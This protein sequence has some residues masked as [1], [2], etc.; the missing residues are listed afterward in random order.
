M[1]YRD[2]FKSAYARPSDPNFGPYSFQERL[3]CE[4]W[5]DLLDVPTGMGKTASVVLAWLWKRGW[6]QDKR[7]ESPETETPRRLVYCL[8]MRVLVE[9]TYRN[10]ETWLRN[11]G[12]GGHAGQGKVSVHLLMGGSDDVEKAT[13]AEHPEEDMI[14]IGTQDM[15]LSRALNRGYG[16]IRFKWPVHFGL[17]NQDCMWVMDEIQLMGPGLWTSAQLDWMR[18]KRFQALTPCRT[19]WMSATIGT[20]FLKTT[21]RKKDGLDQFEPFDPELD[22]PEPIASV[23]DE[24]KRRRSA[25]RPVTLFK[26]EGGKKALPLH[27][28]IAADACKA[29]GEGTLTLVICNTVQMAQDIFRCLADDGPPK[30]LL[31]SRFRGCDRQAAESTLSE[32][33]ARRSKAANGR[34]DG[35]PGLVCVSTQVVEAGIDIS[36]HRLWS[37]LAPWPSM[38]QRLGRLNRDGRDND[39]KAYVWERPNP[40]KWKHD[41]ENWIG[42]YREKELKDA[43]VLLDALA[44]PSAREPF[45]Q[46]V[47]ELKEIKDKSGKIIERALEPQFEP[48][49]RALDVHG[50]FSTEPDT[51]GGFTDVSRFVRGDDPDADVTVF[52]RNWS[53]GAPPEV[54]DLDGPAF[55]SQEEGCAVAVSR[56]KTVLKS[57]NAKAWIWSTRN[58]RWESRAVNEL[59]PGMVV[60]LHADVGGY[61]AELG[62]TG[63]AADKLQNL[64][65]PGPGGALQRDERVFVGYWAP[66]NAHL[67]D[68]RSEAKKLCD[69]VGLIANDEQTKDLPTAVI[70][71]LRTAV[72]EGAGLHDLGKLHPDWQASLPAGDVIGEGPWAKAPYVL[73]VEPANL[74]AETRAEIEQRLPGSLA[75]APKLD[76][77]DQPVGLRW[78][79]DRK[80]KRDEVDQIRSFNGI[81]EVVHEA[82]R[83]GLRHEAASALAMWRRYRDGG[84]PYPALAVYLTAAHHGKVRTVLRSIKGEGDDVFGVRPDSEAFKFNG[85][86][87][88]MDFSVAV[89]GA[90]GEWTDEG[91]VLTGHGWTGLVADLLGSWCANSEDEPASTVV[92]DSEP[93]HLGPFVLAWLEALVRVADWRASDPEIATDSIKPSEVSNGK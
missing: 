30:I 88:P 55:D 33:E 77:D 62:W 3:A 48:Y 78:A 13:W 86:S 16:M 6:R 32:F 2:F 67:R 83:P 11:L 27:E 68:A 90:E 5:P 81:N 25:R 40:E 50:L 51:H 21:D 54:D 28:Q 70:K 63:K 64:P 15:L 38:I 71:D 53:G 18:R 26:P 59:T 92:P 29:H 34:I 87:W 60:M 61:S 65:P 41:G 47:A 14:L 12:I 35:D 82:F 79:I 85:V 89:D 76:K 93:H 4:P 43:K 22:K 66:L 44:E 37:E 39:A 31:T 58:D 73:R 1:K 57:R 45:A 80:L 24:L 36:A 10:T 69:R 17:L 74:S 8:P 72:I 20:S 52:W 84:A 75:L 42:P 19:L 23:G 91:F 7:A 49:P 9:Q 46:A 56:L